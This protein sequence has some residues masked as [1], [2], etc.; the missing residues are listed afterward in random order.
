[1]HRETLWEFLRLRGIPREIL[2]LIRALYTGTK[3][4]VRWGGDTS[5]FFPVK[6]GVR[7][8]CVLA[9][10]LFSVCMDWL[11]GRTVGLGL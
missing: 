11:L 8:G 10:Y 6:T 1:M 5:E 2:E 4:A 3:S 9:P 7:K